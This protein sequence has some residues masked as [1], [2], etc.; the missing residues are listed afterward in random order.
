MKGWYQRTFNDWPSEGNKAKLKEH[1]PHQNGVPDQQPAGHHPMISPVFSPPQQRQTYPQNEPSYAGQQVSSVNSYYRSAS[2]PHQAMGEALSLHH[3]LVQNCHSLPGHRHPQITSAASHSMYQRGGPQGLPNGLDQQTSSRQYNSLPQQNGPGHQ[4]D[5][6]ASQLSAGAIRPPHQQNHLQYRQ[7]DY[8]QQATTQANE[9][10]NPLRQDALLETHG[11]SD[12]DI[13][14][15]NFKADDTFQKLLDTDWFHP[16]GPFGGGL[17]LPVDG[18]P[19][20]L[21]N[22]AA[23]KQFI[24]ASDDHPPQIP[25]DQGTSQATAK[26][27]T[28]GSD[29]DK[30]HA[31]PSHQHQSSALKGQHEPARGSSKHYRS[32]SILSDP[33]PPPQYPLPVDPPINSRVIHKG[34]NMAW[35]AVLIRGRSMVTVDPDILPTD[36]SPKRVKGVG[37]K[38]HD[39]M[40][41]HPEHLRAPH[42][43]APSSCASYAEQAAA[44]P[45][46]L[47]NRPVSSTN[48]SVRSSLRDSGYISILDSA[49]VESMRSSFSTLKLTDADFKTDYKEADDGYVDVEITTKGRMRRSLIERMHT[50]IIGLDF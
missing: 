36:H 27:S 4:S 47:S 8:P 44:A 46:P 37:T 43:V 29:N 1:Q 45:V 22:N 38:S 11:P 39:S 13:N 31:L 7:N 28:T 49:V 3:P 15:M 6:N 50:P 48:V 12:R 33:T 16:D 17:N 10:G 25:N 14:Q 30:M 2:S 40:V 24:L 35:R 21:Q 23:S 20:G 9:G 42:P 19:S 18:Q 41:I 26:S 32:S 34:S 5:G